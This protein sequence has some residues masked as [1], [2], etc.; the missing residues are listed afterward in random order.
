MLKYVHNTQILRI[1]FKWQT[2]TRAS[3][4]EKSLNLYLLDHR[5]S[6]SNIKRLNMYF[7]TAHFSFYHRTFFSYHCTN[8]LTLHTKI[9]YES[10]ILTW[11]LQSRLNARFIELTAHASNKLCQAA[12][13]RWLSAA[14]S[15]KIAERKGFKQQPSVHY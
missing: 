1:I 10:T 6:F 9:R 4:L 15:W 12:R 2:R 13:R 11:S 3:T 8:C 14:I 7:I 5:P